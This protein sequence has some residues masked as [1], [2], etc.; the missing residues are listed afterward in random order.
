MVI[1]VI[2]QPA[3]TF[4][5]QVPVYE[6]TDAIQSDRNSG[7]PNGA[8]GETERFRAIGSAIGILIISAMSLRVE[9]REPP[10]NPS[11]ALRA[12]S[13]DARPS[14]NELQVPQTA[15]P[16]AAKPAHNKQ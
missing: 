2:N 6:M 5:I 15:T 8:Q 3:P 12:G 9:S 13:R 11:T 7:S 10:L 14:I 1:C 4:C 16:A